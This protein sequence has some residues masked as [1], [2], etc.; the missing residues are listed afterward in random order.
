MGSKE[1][2]QEKGLSPLTVFLISEIKAYNTLLHLIQ[3]SLE[4]VK[5]CL[6]G[7]SVFTKET[8]E[9][10]NDLKQTKVPKKWSIHPTNKELM[11]WIKETIK[12]VEFIRSWMVNGEPK[13][14]WTP[15]L[16][17][18]KGFLAALTQT[19]LKTHQLTSEVLGYN[20]QVIETVIIEKP[21]EG[22]IIEGLQLDNGI[23]N[24]EK[25]LLDL[26]G[27]TNIIPPI[28]LT[29]KRI[30]EDSQKGY[31][32]PIYRN[33]LAKSDV[34]AYALLPTRDESDIWVLRKTSLLLE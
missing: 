25:G 34:L 17:S 30:T 11:D 16:I 23:W 2:F 3:T 7:D 1:L 8:E 26:E 28:H 20:F 33:R 9:I 12:K 15:A 13:V 4:E 29:I 5:N 22:V 32:C 21:K 19:Y 31:S 24:K 27:S 14:Y 18:F 10:W 6:L